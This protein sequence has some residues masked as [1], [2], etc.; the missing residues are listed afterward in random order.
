MS[1]MKKLLAWC[2]LFPASILPAQSLDE[3]LKQASSGPAA[4]SAA[5]ESWLEARGFERLREA[6]KSAKPQNAA[7]WHAVA[8][9]EERLMRQD[10]ALA[11]WK[12]ACGMKSDVSE[13]MRLGLMRALARGRHFA[14]ALKEVEALDDATL[15]PETAHDLLWLLIG[16]SREQDF[17]SAAMARLRKLAAARPDDIE[18]QKAFIRQER[19]INGSGAVQRRIREGLENDPAPELR[20][21]WQLFDIQDERDQGRR[22]ELVAKA[23][24]LLE[25][26]ASDEETERTV[27]EHLRETFQN[28]RDDPKFKRTPQEI[29]AKFPTRAAIVRAM[30]ELLRE[31]GETAEAVKLLGTLPADESAKRLLLAWAAEDDREGDLPPVVL[32]QVSE[33]KGALD[34]PPEA[35]WK[36]EMEAL[37]DAGAR[38]TRLVA[39]RREFPADA[40]VAMALI[41]A[42]SSQQRHAEA[43]HEA[44]R[45]HHLHAQDEKQRREWWERLGTNQT[46][47]WVIFTQAQAMPWLRDDPAFE[48]AVKARNGQQRAADRIASPLWREV[49]VLLTRGMPR[50]ASRVMLEQAGE[51]GLDAE[52]AGSLAIGLM[53]SREWKDAVVFLGLQRVRFPQDYRL[54]FLHGLALKGGGDAAGAEEV[55]LKMGGFTQEIRRRTRGQEGYYPRGMRGQFPDAGLEA[56]VG[57]SQAVAAS[58]Q[59]EQLLARWAQE[60]AYARNMDHLMLSPPSVK[61]AGAWGLVQLLEMAPER[62]AA[63]R[64]ALVER[65]RAAGLP[66]PELLEAGKVTRRVEYGTELSVDEAWLAEHLELDWGSQILLRQLQM[67]MHLP[68]RTAEQKNADAATARQSAAALLTKKPSAALQAALLAWQ[69]QPEVEMPAEVPGALEKVDAISASELSPT[70]ATLPLEV[71]RKVAGALLPLVMALAGKEGVSAEQKAQLGTCALW[72]GAWKE[73]AGLA[74]NYQSPGRLMQ[75]ASPAWAMMQA[76]SPLQWPPQAAPW[77]YGFPPGGPPWLP[78][79]EK[80]AFLAAAQELKNPGLR[81]AWLQT[82]GDAAGAEKEARAWL[83]AEPESLPAM[84]AAASLLAHEKKADEALDLLH[85]WARRQKDADQRRLGLR[86][87]LQAAFYPSSGQALSMMNEAGRPAMP[88]PPPKHAKRLQQAARELLPEV[89]H[90]AGAWAGAWHPV[91]QALDLGKGEAAPGL[92]RY[93]QGIWQ[94]DEEARRQQEESWRDRRERQQVS[95]YMVKKM[96]EAGKKAQALELTL[97][98]LRRDADLRFRASMDRQNAG[99]IEEWRQVITSGEMSAELVKAAT[100]QKANDTHRLA[101]AVHVAEV[102][103]DWPQVVTWAE[104]ALKLD[105]VWP[106]MRLAL[107]DARQ[108]LSG[109]PAVLVTALRAMPPAEARG[110]LQSLLQQAQQTADFTQRLSVA[111]AAITILSESPEVLSPEVHKASAFIGMNPHGEILRS[112]FE[113]LTQA[114][115]NRQ[116]QR[117]APPL[118]PGWSNSRDSSQGTSEAVAE[119]PVLERRKALHEQLCELASKHPEWAETALRPLTARHLIDGR[120]SQEDLHA[121]ARKAMAALPQRAPAILQAWTSQGAPVDASLR[122]RLAGLILPLLEDAWKGRENDSWGQSGLV[123]LIGGQIPPPEEKKLPL[124]ALWEEPQDIDEGTPIYTPEQLALNKQR[125]E[126]MDQLWKTA[127]NIPALKR[128]VFPAW[129]SYRLHFIESPAEVIEAAKGIEA[130]RGGRSVLQSFVQLASQSYS[131]QHHILTA[132]VVEALLRQQPQSSPGVQSSQKQMLDQTM[133]LLLEGRSQQYQPMPALI[134]SANEAE[135]ILGKDW[136]KRRLDVLARFTDLLKDQDIQL[137]PELL[138]T[139][140]QEALQNGSDTSKIEAALLKQMTANSNACERALITFIHTANGGSMHVREGSSAGV[141]DLKRRLAWFETALRLGKPLLNPSPYSSSGSDEWL[142]S[143][144]EAL[145]EDCETAEPP[146]PGVMGLRINRTAPELWVKRYQEDPLLT[147]RDDLLLQGLELESLR[148]NAWDRH[149]VQFTLLQLRRG[150]KG[151]EHML[152]FLDK[153]VKTKPDQVLGRYLS[154]WRHDHCYPGEEA[155]LAAGHLLL[156]VLKKLPSSSRDSS[157]E[158]F[159]GWQDMVIGARNYHQSSKQIP[160]LPDQPWLHANHIDEVDIEMRQPLA[161]ERLAVWKQILE[162]CAI[163]PGLASLAFP[164]LA[165]LHVE[166]NPARLLEIA[167]AFTDEEW[168]EAENMLDSLL[169]QNSQATL[170]RRA[171]WGRFALLWEDEAAKRLKRSP[172][173]AQHRRWPKQMLEYLREEARTKG[174]HQPRPPDSTA[175]D[176]A[177]L[178]EVAT[179]Y[180]ARLEQDP[181]GTPEGFSLHARNLFKAGEAPEGVLETARR[182]MARQPDLATRSLQTWCGAVMAQKPVSAAECLWAGKVLLSLAEEWPDTVEASWATN[183]ISMLGASLAEQPRPAEDQLGLLNQL[184]D[185]VFQHRILPQSIVRAI[186]SKLLEAIK[187]APRISALASKDPRSAGNIMTGWLSFQ[188]Y[189]QQAIGANEITVALAVL[190]EWPANAD[191]AHLAWTEQFQRRLAP[192]T[193]QPDRMLAIGGQQLPVVIFPAASPVAEHRAF[194]SQILA[195]LKKRSVS[196]PWTHALEMR[197]ICHS[198]ADQATLA[199]SLEPFFKGDLLSRSL[200]WIQNTLKIDLRAHYASGHHFQ[201]TGFR[202][203]GQAPLPEAIAEEVID[204]SRILQAAIREKWLGGTESSSLQQ[205]SLEQLNIVIAKG[206]QNAEETRRHPMF[207]TNGVQPSQ[208]AEAKTLLADWENASKADVSAALTPENLES[209]VHQLLKSGTEP[210]IIAGRVHALLASQ[211]KP[212]SDAM[213]KWARQSRTRTDFDAF[214]RSG[215]FALRVMESWGANL[216]APDWLPVFLETW[217]QYSNQPWELT[218]AR[219]RQYQEEAEEVQ[220]ALHAALRRFPTCRHGTWFPVMAAYAHKTSTPGAAEIAGLVVAHLMAQPRSSMPQPRLPSF[221]SRDPDFLLGPSF[222]NEPVLHLLEHLAST[223]DRA[224][225]SKEGRPAIEHALGGTSGEWLGHFETLAIC[226]RE[227]W[228]RTVHQLA[229]YGRL[230]NAYQQ[231]ANYEPYQGVA[232]MLRIAALRKMEIGLETWLEIAGRLKEDTFASGSEMWL[233]VREYAG[234]DAVADLRG[235]LKGYLSEDYASPGMHAAFRAVPRSEDGV[236]HGYPDK[237]PSLAGRN[238]WA[239]AYRMLYSLASDSWGHLRAVMEV[240]QELGYH[241]LDG[242]LAHFIA[243]QSSTSNT[244]RA[245]KEWERLLMASK[246]TSVTPDVLWLQPH[247]SAAPIW[248]FARRLELHRLVKPRQWLQERN[249]AKPALGTALLLLSRDYLFGHPVPVASIEEMLTPCRKELEHASK[250]QLAALSAALQLLQPMLPSAVAQ[251]DKTSVLKL[252]PA[253]QKPSATTSKKETTRSDWLYSSNEPRERLAPLVKEVFDKLVSNHDQEA[254]ES[255]R[256]NIALTATETW[257]EELPSGMTR[258]N[259][260]WEQLALSMADAVRAFPGMATEEQNKKL[261]ALIRYTTD[262]FERFERLHGSQRLAHLAVFQKSFSFPGRSA[263]IEA[264]MLAVLLPRELGTKA[265]LLLP[266]VRSL[267]LPPEL[268]KAELTRE[269]DDPWLSWA[270]LKNVNRDA[271]PPPTPD[272]NNWPPVLLLRMANLDASR[273]SVA[274]RHKALEFWTFSIRSLITHDDE[275]CLTGNGLRWLDGHPH[276]PVF[277]SAVIDAAEAMKTWLGSTH[278]GSWSTESLGSESSIA[279]SIIKPLLTSLAQAKANSRRQELMQAAASASRLAFDDLLQELRSSADA[280]GACEKWW[281]LYFHPSVDSGRRTWRQT[282][283]DLPR[284]TQQDEPLFNAVLQ[285]KLDET[286]RRTALLILAFLMD[287]ESMPPKLA[288]ARRI[289]LALDGLNLENSTHLTALNRAL[290]IQ[291]ALTTLLPE[292]MPVLRR[293]PI[294]IAWRQTGQINPKELRVGTPEHHSTIEMITLTAAADA[295]LNNAPSEWS[296]WTNFLATPS[297]DKDSTRLVSWSRAMV[298]ISLANLQKHWEKTRQPAQWPD[299][300]RLWDSIPPSLTQELPF[301]YPTTLKARIAMA[302]NTPESRQEAISHLARLKWTPLSVEIA[303]ETATECNLTPLETL[304]FFASSQTSKAFGYL[305]YRL[306][307]QAAQRSALAREHWHTLIPDAQPATLAKLAGGLIQWLEEKGDEQGLLLLARRLSELEP[308]ALAPEDWS[309]LATAAH[310]DPALEFLLAKKAAPASPKK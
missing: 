152:A 179:R 174:P 256:Q 289:Q 250:E 185:R 19:S 27:L 105:P 9:L 203:F 238:K 291:G 128:E 108:R 237:S 223:Q 191:P 112:L 242:C 104:A 271:P 197:L 43:L 63:S 133:L 292:L 240:A 89:R 64:L 59:A 218:L 61:A 192:V 225:W 87:Y 252:L 100:P 184:L 151:L 183:A 26:V 178:A 146:V 293:H 127:H 88:P 1:G 209:I 107:A 25:K 72:L 70:L 106:A 93:Q 296:R 276:T 76:S 66:L 285:S 130:P 143:W 263:K 2:L 195:E 216:P 302:K 113:L 16:I 243:Q 205:S 91:F 306:V 33:I 126:L 170:A 52:L 82:G 186:P 153:L 299:F 111:Q 84:L 167:K 74:A 139:K 281:P 304:T 165:H 279:Q 98:Q 261:D 198:S 135:R 182:L 56:W 54:A 122:Y 274:Q 22:E 206:N 253:T 308:P 24:A 85:A 259:W 202:Q 231:G 246:L 305:Q 114:V 46:A 67:R 32:P 75:E 229:T 283:S 244:A 141:W 34:L 245:V 220:P 47:T 193:P 41:E 45:M 49:F 157:P 83:K 282:M 156:E 278:S 129:A 117:V 155:Q 20:T 150:K 10:E 190:K 187:A 166:T 39:L 101:Q 97:R 103:A 51:A 15:S 115:T 297:G 68:G 239:A 123:E 53:A 73:A 280:T 12:A 121:Y 110:S 222:H 310:A 169:S 118:Y 144:I 131:N 171:A 134:V 269:K 35:A 294:V 6:L 124:F 194:Q 44:L 208:T 60:V 29:A 58:S 109:D 230:P 164:D 36:A 217:K 175:E 251:A 125:R 7:D 268:I 137:P 136:Q 13:A 37:T 161:H 301:D 145:K 21:L 50:L 140:L 199:R 266:F 79:S 23:M 92:D 214:V 163:M 14:E 78:E 177:S 284:F 95:S 18:T 224:W 65:A 219:A 162:Q 96:L 138:F 99:Q 48:Q 277:D 207:E 11:A 249:R 200:E 180:A 254:D 265:L 172:E 255:A 215:R 80:A 57:I 8:L 257:Q 120:P 221:Y 300:L 149:C 30:A 260:L 248:E 71:R 4:L 173:K 81:L 142:N 17:R 204:V 303:V 188:P 119:A 102:C 234:H 160:L 148:E 147:Q 273:L 201:P 159:T 286:C 62:D 258:E 247:G 290:R 40:E 262:H 55:F 210:G 90:L 212:G 270:L 288:R 28:G 38:F 77:F 275:S 154:R 189:F 158:S 168:F 232:W 181:T 235:V 176:R 236:W 227:E 94:G 287:D 42:W 298:W 116:N 272:I 295:L 211:P 3:T 267:R 31:S 226:P 5:L 86:L 264:D 309:K 233:R 213:E 196:L 307:S 132:E 241:H 228:V 69:L